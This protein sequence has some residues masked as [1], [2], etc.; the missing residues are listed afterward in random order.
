MHRIHPRHA[1]GPRRTSAVELQHVHR[2]RAGVARLLRRSVGLDE[3]VLAQFEGDRRWYTGQILLVAG[4]STMATIS[5]TTALS[6]I[7]SQPPLGW[8]VA[9]GLALGAFI[10]T[11]DL[12]I[13]LPDGQHQRRSA[14]TYAGRVAFS[15]LMGGL[16]AMPLTAAL[17]QRDVDHH[18]EQVR[19]QAATD[20]EAAYQQRLTDTRAAVRAAHAPSLAAATAARDDARRQADDARHAE[21]AQRGECNDEINGASSGI[22]GEG[23]RA[24]AKC[25]AA[26][27][28]TQRVGETQRQAVQADAAMADATRAEMSDIDASV[29]GVPRPAVAPYRPA[30]LGVIDRIARTHDQLGTVWT[31]AITVA[32]MTLD[33]LP[34]IL[35]LSRGLT[36]YERVLAHRQKAATVRLLASLG[37]AA[38]RSTAAELLDDDPQLDEPILD[39]DQL[40]RFVRARL[41]V[42]PH[43]QAKDLHA[44]ARARGYA[45]EYPTFTRFL[46][47]RQLRPTAGLRPADAAPPAR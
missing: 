22:V 12:T 25:A 17:L 44:L 5:M 28:L 9:F 19:Q 40:E 43:M 23:P 35:K 20:A 24:T 47:V 37:P 7:T 31:L 30:E 2:G 6:M 13:V 1:A 36:N 10:G 39:D 42:D 38:E 21:S 15:L 34:V 11:C 18:E 14:W 16:A 27:Q 46:R 32:L 26:T 3:E 33:T 41:I 29:A 4:V 8:P 45:R